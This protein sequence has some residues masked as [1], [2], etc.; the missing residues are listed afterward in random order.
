MSLALALLLGATV[1]TAPPSLP[2]LDFSTGRLTHWE[3]HGFSIGPAEGHGPTTRLGVCS[4]DRGPAG[5][6]AILH[7]T[8][9][10]PAKAG[11]LRFR[12][13]AVRPKSAAPTPV[14]DVVLEAAGR[15]ILPK[16]VYTASGW[17]PAKELLPLHERRTR[18]YYWPLSAHIGRR[19]RIAI[20]DEDD[21]PGCHVLCGGFSFVEADDI[22]ARE[23]ANHMQQLQ[24]QHRLTPMARFDSRHF[25][26][27]SNAPTGD[28][29][30]R[31]HNCE[32]IY[33]YFFDHFRRRGFAVREPGERL[34][35]A[36][37]DTHTGFEAY[38][39]GRQSAAITGIYHL[40]SNRLI[41][42]DYGTNP[43]F[44]AGKRRLDD[45][46]RRAGNDLE[47]SRIVTLAGRH[48]ADRRNDVNISTVMHEVAHQLSF[49][50]GLLNRK[51]DAPV[52]LVEGLACYCEPTI[53]GG[54]QGIGGPNPMRARNLAGPARG[55]GRFIPLRDLV[56][57]DDWLRK[58]RR[59]E[60][61]ILG[62]AQSWALFS[63]LMKERP[64]ELRRYM[65]MIYHRRT[66]E[67]RLADFAACFG[68]DLARQE[69]RYQA[70]MR[71]VVRDQVGEN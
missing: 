46:A 16:Y 63:Y 5:R 39:G 53:N 23:F 36:V 38:L 15:Q 30:Y 17:R 2:N 3:G 65:A 37:F 64:R 28:T 13:A 50:G 71:R 1:P 42:Y 48:F 20:I 56:R 45:L 32:T 6:K 54:W 12:A 70:Y 33:S 66:P 9:T 43:H 44:V 34:M 51:G 22:N 27:I 61:A 69:Q 26:A 8:F 60:H 11:F 31:L 47:R 29:E 68:A 58:T 57:N 7:R 14:L 21:R 35:V 41:V 62:Y 55:Q 18:D 19:V 40:P 52:W 49:N 25:V 59:A 67:H 24:R 4:S 10:V